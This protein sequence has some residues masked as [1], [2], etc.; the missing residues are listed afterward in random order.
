MKRYDATYLTEAV[1][2]VLVCCGVKQRHAMLLTSHLIQADAYGVHSHGLAVLPGHVQRVLRGG[3]VLDGEIQVVRQTAAFAVID[4]NNLCGMVS[5]HDAM[6][7]A[8]KNVEQS[9]MYAVFS[10]GGNT[11]GAAFSYVLKAAAAGKIGIVFC[12]TPTAMA[13]W[14]GK[15]KRLGTNPIACGIPGRRRGPI[16]LDMATSVV[17][18]SKINEIA[19]TNGTLPHGWALDENGVDTT[20]PH[21]AICGTV[22]PMAAHKG[23]GLATVI[24]CLSGVLSGAAYLDMVGKFYTDVPGSCMNVGQSFFVMDPVQILS[25]DFYLLID[26]YI[27]RLHAAGEEV[28]FPGERELNCARESKQ[29]GIPLAPETVKKLSKLFDTYGVENH[30]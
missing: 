21:R 25:E 4:A 3:Y 1:E 20:D 15:G 28:R 11:F 7:L 12:N 22:L 2:Q 5:A 10:R 8:L 23:Y 14:G 6:A 19:K 26:D 13:P 24:D 27:D 9:G 16:L 18:K 29:L 17:A 30:L